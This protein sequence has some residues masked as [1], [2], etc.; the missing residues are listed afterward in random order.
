[1]TE[2]QA[3]LG[4]SQLKRLETFKQR[5]RAIV[6]LYKKL[7]NSDSRV[8]FLREEKYS[9][10]CFH[11]CPV[12]IEFEKLKIRKE[13]FFKELQIAGLNL[14]VHYIPVYW[15]P[16]YKKMGYEEGLC[17]NAEKYY[18]QT[19]SLPLYPDLSDKDVREIVD[20]FNRVLRVA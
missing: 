6:D 3:A 14:Q 5:R 1:M 12:L 2:M 8:R 10:A 13:V 18:R 17:P 15:Q 9:C 11:L 19:V 4:I 20:R 7:F 16:Y